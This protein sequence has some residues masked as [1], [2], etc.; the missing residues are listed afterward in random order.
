MN[1]AAQP[2]YLRDGHELKVSSLS[3]QEQSQRLKHRGPVV[4]D[5]YL[6]PPILGG[7]HRV[8]QQNDIARTAAIDQQISHDVNILFDPVIHIQVPANQF[9][10]HEKYIQER[11]RVQLA[12]GRAEEALAIRGECLATSPDLLATLRGIDCRKR[13]VIPR[14]IGDRVTGFGDA[15]YQ[16]GMPGR[17]LTHHKERR[18]DLMLFEDR[19][20]LRGIL[21]VGTVVECKG[22]FRLVRYKVP[23]RPEEAF[24][25]SSHGGFQCFDQLST[26]LYQ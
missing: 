10:T 21:G 24:Y 23:H 9:V 17:L 8:V 11:R 1:R 7:E 20:K 5:L 26:P 6:N 4:V 12:E 3:V 13:G 15:T 2:E 18:A 14:V 22:H 16:L 19:Q 25:F